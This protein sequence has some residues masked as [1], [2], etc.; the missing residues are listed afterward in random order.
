M[1][2][3]FVSE[4][5]VNPITWYSRIKNNQTR[6]IKDELPCNFNLSTWIKKLN[7]FHS[8]LE[9]FQVLWLR[10]QYLTLGVIGPILI[11]RIKM[12]KCDLVRRSEF[13]PVHTLPW[14]IHADV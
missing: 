10:S 5:N 1:A 12:T 14:A 9:Y 13:L 4:N 6:L 7:A 3:E 2:G 11:F 8:D